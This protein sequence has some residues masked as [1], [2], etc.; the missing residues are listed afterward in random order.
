ML[1]N[2]REISIDTRFDNYLSL[3]PPSL[4]PLPKKHAIHRDT[5]NILFEIDTLE[6]HFLSMARRNAT[7]TQRFF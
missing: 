7:L 1:L 5:M 6:M 4:P 3:C 2:A